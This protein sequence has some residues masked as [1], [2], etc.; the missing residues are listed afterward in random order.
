MNLH[1]IYLVIAVAFYLVTAHTS[2]FAENIFTAVVIEKKV[3]RDD[4]DHGPRNRL[5]SLLLRVEAGSAAAS[6]TFVLHI[7][8]DTKIMLNSTTQAQFSAIKTGSQVQFNNA[9][10]ALLTE[11]IQINRREILILN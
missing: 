7:D 1:K 9:G 5:G 6:R 11:P 10:P 2:M 8:K 4:H 3:T